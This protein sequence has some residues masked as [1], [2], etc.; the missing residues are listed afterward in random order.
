MTGPLGPIPMCGSCGA[1][2]Q[3][4]NPMCP[5]CRTIQWVQEPLP[6]PVYYPVPMAP[7]KSPGLAAFPSFLW[8]GV[9][10]VYAGQTGLGIALLLVNIPLVILGWTVIGMLVAFPL[11]LIAVVISMV[12][13]AQAASAF[14]QRIYY[15]Y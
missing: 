11:W 7:P 1:Y 8:L 3:P 5:V 9:G 4:P 15:R 13:A 2:L 10:N 6:Q 14:N 12:T